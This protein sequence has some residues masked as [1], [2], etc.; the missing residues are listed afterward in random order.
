MDH[1]PTTMVHISPPPSYPTKPRLRKPPTASNHKT[2]PQ[3]SI[4]AGQ[5]RRIRHHRTQRTHRSLPIQWPPH[6]D[7]LPQHSTSPHPP[8]LSGPA[9]NSGRLQTHRHQRTPR[10]RLQQQRHAITTLRAQG[11]RPASS[12]RPRLQ[13]S[14]RVCT[15]E[16][17]HIGH[18]LPTTRTLYPILLPHLLLRII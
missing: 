8:C 6:M 17:P 18:H 11:P 15:D 3:Q 12:R 7:R 9:T 10:A 14:R 1:Q 4:H 5:L 2:G 13:Q 16:P